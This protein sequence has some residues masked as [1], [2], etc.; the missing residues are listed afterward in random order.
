MT[1]KISGYIENKKSEMLDLIQTLVNIDSGSS[2][3]AGV[4]RVGHILSDA[5]E[6]EGFSIEIIKQAE[7]GNH[8]VAKKA[9]KGK[10]R[11]LLVGHMDTVFPEGTAKERPFTVRGNRAYGP[12]VN[13]MKSGLASLLY[14]IKALYSECSSEIGAITVVLNGDEEVGSPTSRPII[15]EEAKK[16]DAVFIVEPGQPTGAIVTR[17][18]GVGIF[19]LQITGRS[20]HAGNNPADGIS[21]IEELAH[22]IIE[23]HKLS[24]LDSGVTVNVGIIGGGSRRNVVADQAFADIDLRIKTKE[25]GEEMLKRLHEIADKPNLPGVKISLT[26]GINRPPMMKT[27][28]TE[29]LYTLVKEAGKMIG[30]DLNEAFP[31]GA[32]D[33][34][35]T[36]ALGIPTI[37]AMGP[38]G[39]F[40]HSDKEYLEIEKVTERCK[41]LALSLLLVGRNGLSQ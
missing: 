34:N 27:Q 10:G 35:F 2:F 18:K 15:E 17:R 1:E 21:A 40:S 38:V 11:I 12:G 6:K 36:A 30:L 19:K 3:K 4:D 16:V 9:G 37:D 28:G 20:A 23:L 13:D 32:S 5:L 8:I 24:D 29:L 14:A 26:G 33:G 31:G 7:Y 25:Q 39:G 41:L 22:K